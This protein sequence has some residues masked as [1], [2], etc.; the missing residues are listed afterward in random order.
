[1]LLKNKVAII[2]GSTRGIGK[3]TASLFLKNEAKVVINGFKKTT[4][5]HNFANDSDDKTICINADVSK[6]KDVKSLTSETLKKFGKIDIL[7]NNAGSIYAPRDWRSDTENWHKTLD[8]N[9]TSAWL[10]I[11]EVAPIM[12]R[13]GGGTIVNVSSI[14]GLNGAANSLAYSC[15]K[16]G[17]ITLTKALARE[18]APTIRVNSVAP[19]NVLTDMTRKS[20]KKRTNLFNKVTPLKRSAEPEEIAQA[21]LFLASGA[22]NFITGEILVVD[23]GYSLR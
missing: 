11:R 15:A 3:A 23:G 1:M 16:S 22:S 5:V 2:T 17:L 7:V 19:G 12:L 9:L 14:Y 8:A 6:E 18:F 13:N 4:E 10:M 20:G 21:I